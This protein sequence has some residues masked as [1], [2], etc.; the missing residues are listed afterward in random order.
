MYRLQTGSVVVALRALEHS[1][2]VLA[3][4]ALEHSSVV[5]ALGL[6]C[7]VACGIFLDQGWSWSALHLQVDSYPLC[8]QGVW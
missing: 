7:S 2:V 4:G 3:F 8:Q 5:V 6:S 1:S